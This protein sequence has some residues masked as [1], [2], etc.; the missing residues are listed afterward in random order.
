MTTSPLNILFV[1]PYVPASVRLRPF[2]LISQLSKWNK[3]TVVCLVQPKWEA[4]YLSEVQP[5]CENIYPVYPDKVRSYWN[6]FKS[7]PA[8]VPL[9]VAY[10]AMD[11]M[12]DVIHSLTQSTK[13]D[14]IHTEFIRAAQYTMDIQCYPK[15][16]DAVD[17]LTLAYKRALESKYTRIVHRFLAYFEW[18][19]IHK[20]E[21]YILKKYDYGIVSSPEDLEFLCNHGPIIEVLP[22]GVDLEYL[23]WSEKE[24]QGEDIITFLAKMS[25]YVN[26][27]SIF[28][29]VRQIYPIIKKSRPKVRLNIVGYNPTKAVRSLEKDPSITVVGGVPDF[30]PYISQ[31]KVSIAPMV[32]GS[33]I[34]NKILQSMAIGTPVVSTTIATLALQVINGEQILIADHPEEFARAVISLLQ[35]IRLR[36]KISRN[37]RAY[38][39][40]FHNWDKIGVRLDN[41]YRSLI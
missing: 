14:L 13:F 11:E 19:K 38:V 26:V 22:N 37:A 39:E 28:Y 15:V 8:S 9:S 10:S 25:Y 29:F 18:L 16:F 4:N 2:R 32:S 40:E 27:D 6:A 5:F 7:L 34:Q 41:I 21:P 36:Q 3:I 1:T 33:G 20:Y 35:D 31:A 12:H 17:S 24:D 30:R 23:S